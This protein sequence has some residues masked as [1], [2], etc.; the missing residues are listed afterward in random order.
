MAGLGLPLEVDCNTRILR[1]DLKV[2]VGG[3]CRGREEGKEPQ[4]N[5]E[6]TKVLP[7]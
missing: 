1:V 6:V 7:L 4:T 5:G 2:V 3:I